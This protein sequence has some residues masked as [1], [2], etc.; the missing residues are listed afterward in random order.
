MEERHRLMSAI[1]AYPMVEN[2]IRGYK[3]KT[4]GEHLVSM[5]RLF[6][7]AAALLGV[8]RLNSFHAQVGKQ[9]LPLFG[10]HTHYE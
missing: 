4:I 6:D 2:A 1:C 9:R 7:A 10:Q 8:C 5:G 3:G